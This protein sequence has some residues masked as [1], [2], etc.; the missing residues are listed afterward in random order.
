[1]DDR[2]KA[3]IILDAIDR[4]A[5]VIV[6]WNMEKEWLKAI[7]AGLEKVKETEADDQ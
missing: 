1:M 6:N 3:K 2:E 4:E 5:P 7:E